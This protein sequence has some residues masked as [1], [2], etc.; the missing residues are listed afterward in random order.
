MKRSRFSQYEKEFELP[1]DALKV[2]GLSRCRSSY[3]ILYIFVS[4]FFSIA[5]VMHILE[6]T[7]SQTEC[8]LEGNSALLRRNVSILID[9]F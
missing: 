8:S 9:S 1:G 3:V 6:L 4:E 7:L 5:T 2:V